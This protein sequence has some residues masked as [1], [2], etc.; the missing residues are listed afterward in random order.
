MSKLTVGTQ[1]YLWKF[2]N[3]YAKKLISPYDKL[4]MKQPT[5]YKK[6]NEIHNPR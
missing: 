3:I 4:S 6:K 1:I 5:L 2:I